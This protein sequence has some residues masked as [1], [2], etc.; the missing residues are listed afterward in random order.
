MLVI[1][2]HIYTVTPL[3]VLAPEA[4]SCRDKAIMND[5]DVLFICAIS[6]TLTVTVSGKG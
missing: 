2:T 4:T 3:Y 6:P 5:D 1:E